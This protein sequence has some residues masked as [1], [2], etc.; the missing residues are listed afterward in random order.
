MDK[1]R[2]VRVVFPLLVRKDGSPRKR[3]T[4]VVVS[5][6]ADVLVMKRGVSHS[7]PA[8]VAQV[9][10]EKVCVGRSSFECFIYG[11]SMTDEHRKAKVARA[12]KTWFKRQNRD[13]IT[14]ELRHIQPLCYVVGLAAP[15]CLVV[16]EPWPDS[17][18]H[19]QSDT[20]KYPLRN[21]RLFDP[22]LKAG[23]WCSTAHVSTAVSGETVA[24]PAV[25]F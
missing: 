11:S 17:E 15:Q 13:P 3:Q 23:D 16:A 14:G 9:C 4:P 12:V 10:A 7:V 18:L 6:G 21:V 20:K 2:L 25:V 24:I 19:M 5:N 22:S 8:W 1:M